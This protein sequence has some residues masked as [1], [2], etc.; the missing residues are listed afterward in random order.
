[1]TYIDGIALKNFRGIG[2]DFQFAEPLTEF[3][4][5]IGENNS[6]KSTF[7]EF[8][9]RYLSRIGSQEKLNLD[10]LNNLDRHIGGGQIECMTGLLKE[11]FFSSLRSSDLGLDENQI[12][13]I[14]S[15]VEAISYRDQVWLHWVEP[16]DRSQLYVPISND[17]LA[18]IFPNASDWQRLWSRL[19]G[20]GG[21]GLHQH[22]I[23]GI[24]EWISRRLPGSFVNAKIIPAKRVVGPSGQDFGDFSGKGLIDRL[25]QLQNP[26]VEKRPDR[27]QFDKINLFLKSVLQNPDCEIEI[28]HDRRHILVHLGG[29]TLPL[30]SF[31]TGIHEIILIASFCTITNEQILCI[32]EPEIHLH[33][34]LQ[35][36]LLRYLVEYTNNQYFIASH[37]NSLLDS[38]VGTIF[39]TQLTGGL[40]TIRSAVTNSDKFRICCDLGYRPS[41]IL[42]ANCVIWVEG[43][44]DRVY[45]NYWISQKD[46]SLR[47]GI[48][49]SVM[50]YGGRLL[51]HLSADDSQISDFI[52]L[53]PINR[54]VAILIDSDL[55]SGE[56]AIR[57]TKSRVN[58]EIINVGGFSWITDGR[59]IENYVPFSLRESAVKEVHKNCVRLTSAKHKFG[60][61]LEFLRTDG[62]TQ[63]EKFDKLAIAKAVI[64]NPV[65]WS[66][67]DLEE[68]VSGLVEFIKRHN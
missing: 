53:L 45:I 41:D 9:A 40:T 54:A 18:T 29:K 10:T 24:L 66:V 47:E 12:K 44:S 35:K 55:G 51:S 13:S 1:M 64:N 50:F 52:Q 25:A 6:G 43:P 39:H 7:L 22:W 33:P 21:G 11:R 49:Y 61:P 20:S 17:V 46:P 34:I 68:K 42:Q 3:N 56:Q 27:R 26:D 2:R 37:S 8:I 65:D 36:K 5:F 59:E 31:G 23:P 38:E 14:E 30:S 63:S 60:K 48:E 67:L 57:A 16:F 4:F 19:T 58:N 62:K 15:I 32:E 28:P